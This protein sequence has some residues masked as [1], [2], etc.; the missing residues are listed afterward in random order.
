MTDVITL[1]SYAADR[2]LP[3]AG[4]AELLSAVDSTVVAVLPGA[5]DV[6]EMLDHARR[7]GSSA[8][9]RLTFEA[10]GKLIRALAD[11]LSARKEE[12]YELSY[13]TGAT[14]ADSAFDIEGGIGALYVYAS[15]AK[16]LP[17]T[18][19]LV[20]GPREAISKGNFAGQ[21]ILSPLHG[22]A[23]HI[24]AYNFPVWG[25]LEKLGPTL[26]AGMPA[27][28]KPASVGAFVTAAAFRIMID[29][30]VLPPGALQLLLGPTGDL[31]DRL[32]GQDAVA[33]TGSAA[34]AAKLKAQPNI[35]RETVR[36]TAEQ[37]SLNASILGA[38]ATPDS[39]EFDFFVKEVVREMTQK[40]GQKCTAIR[41]ALV[42]V[43]LVDDVERAI[44]ARLGKI[45]VGNP[46]A[47]GVRMGALAGL[48]QRDDVRANIAKLAT[49]ARIVSQDT[50]FVDADDNRGAFLAPTLLRCDDPVHATLVH[51]VEAFGPVSTL[52]PYSDATQATALARAGKGS[53]VL[54]LFT[55]DPKLVDDIVLGTASSHGRILI[56]DRD[57]AADSTGH[58]AA[59]PHLLH[60][61]PGRAGGGAELG[62][63]HGMHHY[64]QRTAVQAAPATLDLVGQL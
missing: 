33:F 23:I 10:R 44:I 51:Q 35:L 49:E 1:A 11:A 59:L 43:N 28:V 27:I 62:G 64:L 21:H 15:K 26:L 4:G 48:P 29:T 2:W 50:A 34:T 7:V 41:R 58:G 38:D 52:M 5:A 31:L 63:L 17:D 61:G 37:D 12:L 55:H 14:R 22:A 8:L 32:D 53:L 6:G 47:E 60:G 3:E 39:P 16:E 30:G 46:R 18:H 54:S 57:S 45:A 42:P 9:R 24:N 56:V 19:V 20:D 40:A 13:A 25:M 36:F